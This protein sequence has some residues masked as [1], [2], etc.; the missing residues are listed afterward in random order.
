M[1]IVPYCECIRSELK[2]PTSHPALAIFDVFNGQCTDELFSLLEVHNIHSV[3]I[4]HNCTNRLQTLDL[5]S[6]QRIIF[7]GNF[8]SGMPAK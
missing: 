4:P 1:I 3:Y 2:L 6:Q 5:T 7:G 8:S